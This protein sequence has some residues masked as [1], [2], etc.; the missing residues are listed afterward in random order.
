[1]TI[2]NPPHFFLAISDAAVSQIVNGF[3]WVLIAIGVWVLIRVGQRW[4]K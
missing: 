4:G 2:Q 3:I 1:M